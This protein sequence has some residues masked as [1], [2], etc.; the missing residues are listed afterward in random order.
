VPQNPHLI[1]YCGF[2][3]TWWLPVLTTQLHITPEVC[4]VLSQCGIINFDISG[5]VI[6]KADASPLMNTLYIGSGL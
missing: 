2:C 3:G 5:E 4:E 1:V 6:V